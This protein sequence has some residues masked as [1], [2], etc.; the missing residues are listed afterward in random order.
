MHEY[1]SNPFKKDIFLEIDWKKNPNNSQ[2]NKPPQDLI[3]KFIQNFE[4][5]DITLHIDIGE[6]GGGEEIPS[7]DSVFSFSKLIDLYW[8]FFLHNDINNP[9]KGIFHYGVVC[10]YCPDLNFPFNGW[11]HMDSFAIS[12][13]W[14]LEQYPRKNIGQIIVGAAIHHLGHTLG[15]LA[16]T[17]D[18]IDNIGVTKPFT[19]QCIKFRNYKSCM[20]YN[21]K[22]EI[23]SYSDGTHGPGDFNDWNQLNLSFFK[24][25][26]FMYNYNK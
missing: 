11:D 21:Y 17:F 20:N 25:S 12:S 9:R 3:N 22:Y 18:G 7:Y 2:T 14:L 6:L 26:N 23:F 4:K 8:N 19:I 5:H 1:N 13:E 15:L 24:N 16:D 10:N